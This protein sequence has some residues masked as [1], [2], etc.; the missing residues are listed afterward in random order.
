M[1]G[2]ASVDR[3]NKATLL[4]TGPYSTIKSYA[5]DSTPRIVKLQDAS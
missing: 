3:N 1:D 5:K 2:L 4:L